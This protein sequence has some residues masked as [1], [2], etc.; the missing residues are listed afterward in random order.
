MVSGGFIVWTTILPC[1][2]FDADNTTFL[3][4]TTSSRNREMKLSRKEEIEDMTIVSSLL[5]IKYLLVM[6]YLDFIVAE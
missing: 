3:N 4:L 5:F 1:E 2:C 6:T